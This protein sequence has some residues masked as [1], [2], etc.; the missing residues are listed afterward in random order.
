MEREIAAGRTETDYQKRPINVPE[1][2]APP[3]RMTGTQWLDQGTASSSS[4]YRNYGYYDQPAYYRA[5]PRTS[6]VE[7]VPGYQ[8]P[9][10]RWVQKYDGSW[11]DLIPPNTGS[12]HILSSVR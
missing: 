7:Y 10:Q 3:S 1:P 2:P 9:R 4:G 8:V 5:N 12:V 11:L 6:N